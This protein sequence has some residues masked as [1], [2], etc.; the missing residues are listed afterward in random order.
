MV[1]QWQEFLY[2][3][4]YSYSWFEVLFDF[5]KFVEVFGV[6][7]ILC[8]DLDDLDDVIM[9]MIMYDGL[10]IFDCLVEKYENCFLMILL[11]KLYNEMF[12]GEVEIQGVI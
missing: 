10:V 2:G 6:K 11:G 12:L 4:C 8:F 1:C 5:V 9:E 3:E 7:G